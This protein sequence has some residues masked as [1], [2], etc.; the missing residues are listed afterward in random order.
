HSGLPPAYTPDQI[1]AL[2]DGG[3]GTWDIEHLLKTAPLQ[4]HNA[5]F[6]GGGQNSAY[7]ASA[8]YQNQGSNLIG[9]GGSGADFGYQKYNLRLNQTSILGKLRANI[10]LNYTKTRN[11][12]NSVGDNNI[13]ADANRV[14][15]NYN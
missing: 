9:N 6:S 10:I 1:Q 8:G 11:K 14:P 7:Y 13:F 15:H 5:S 4:S 3:N 12:T 2:K